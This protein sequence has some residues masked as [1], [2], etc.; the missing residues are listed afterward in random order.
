M[1]QQLILEFHHPKWRQDYAQEAYALRQI[2]GTNLVDIHHI[3]STAIPGIY[4]KPIIDILVEVSDINAVDT[5]NA[6]LSL[7]GY[8]PKGEFG[9]AGRR[10]FQKGSDKVRRTHH[11]HVFESGTAEVMHHLGFRDFLIAHPCLAKQYS[12]LKQ[13]LLAAHAGNK[14]HYID[15]KGPFIKLIN[16][17]VAHWLRIKGEKQ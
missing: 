10:Y 13:E 7:L 1:S 2:F 8:Q 3:G 14:D 15:G 12:E 16:Q 11:M 4:A 9:I 5:Y 17:K 6:G